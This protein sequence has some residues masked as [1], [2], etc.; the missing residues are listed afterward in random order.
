VWRGIDL[1]L[2]SLQGCKLILQV[3]SALINLIISWLNDKVCL[4]IFVYLL[5]LVIFE[6]ILK[7]IEK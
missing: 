4:L 2:I 5:K 1:M 3:C 6:R 7:W